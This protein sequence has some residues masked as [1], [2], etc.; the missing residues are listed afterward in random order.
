MTHFDC[1]VYIDLMPLVKDGAASFATQK[2]LNDHL[3]ECDSCRALYD[4]LPAAP[5]SPDNADA[6]KTLARLRRNAALG[7]LLVAIVG[8]TV[9]LALNGGEELFYNVLIL[10]AVG[11]AAYYA[12]R[13]YSLLAPVGMF[14]LTFVWFVVQA[15]GTGQLVLNDNG[16]IS[17]SNLFGGAA[18]W[19]ML[20]TGVFSIGVALGWT[21]HLAFSRTS[22][23][24]KWL[25]LGLAAAAVA[26]LCGVIAFANSLMGNPVCKA[27]AQ[28]HAEKMIV[29]QFDEPDLEIERSGFNFKTGG[30]YVK[31]RS[32]SSIDT[33]FT[34]YYNAWGQYHYDT[35]D[36]VTSGQNTHS[37]IND[38][39]HSGVREALDQ[40]YGDENVNIGYGS[41]NADYELTGFTYEEMPALDLRT[42][43]RDALY[44]LDVL[45]AQYGEVTFYLCTTDVTLQRAAATLL[46]VRQLLEAEGLDF[47]AID[48][49]LTQPRH[50]DGTWNNDGPEIRIENFLWE[51]I[52]EEGLEE[53]V[54]AAHDALMAYYAEQDA[55]NAA[56]FANGGQAID[57]EG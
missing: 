23:L 51:D 56:L 24:P 14:G 35:Y 3:A 17:L 52:Y 49:V 34:I 33:H 16:G 13:K 20:Y 28:N 9:G 53:R 36:S 43:Q 54:Q 7:L 41:I 15:I 1:D 40:H 8:A 31:V 29:Q 55:K 44:D 39:Y 25:R 22:R 21:S 30:Y 27:I 18:L 45:G 19:G 46:E 12:L 47:Y 38:A 5:T 42:L 10:P 6:A 2:A 37:R 26:I 4:S 48:F 57:T 32:D 11:C 50:P